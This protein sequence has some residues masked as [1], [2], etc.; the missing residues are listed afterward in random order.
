MH[1]GEKKM[2]LAVEDGNDSPE[3]E[4]NYTMLTTNDDSNSCTL[5]VSEL[6][7]AFNNVEQ[8]IPNFLPDLGSQRNIISKKC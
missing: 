2:L 5:P 4:E 7:L 3:S 8:G 1:Q 6:K